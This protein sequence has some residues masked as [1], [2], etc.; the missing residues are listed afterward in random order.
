MQIIYHCYENMQENL[1]TCVNHLKTM[2]K[3]NQNL[4]W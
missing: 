3:T 2:S 4:Q 1:D